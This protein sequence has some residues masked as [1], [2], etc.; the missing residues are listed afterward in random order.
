MTQTETICPGSHPHVVNTQ[1][2]VSKIAFSLTPNT[3]HGTQTVQLCVRT[4]TLPMTKATKNINL[5]GDMFEK[6]MLGLK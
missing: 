3:M 2:A 4:Q 6:H 5:H 1:A